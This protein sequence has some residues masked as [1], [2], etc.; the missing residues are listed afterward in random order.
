[1]GLGFTGFIGFIVSSGWVSS[2]I[3]LGSGF[4]VKDSEFWVR[5][6]A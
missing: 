4:G 2:S 3:S 5:F 1:M 6:R